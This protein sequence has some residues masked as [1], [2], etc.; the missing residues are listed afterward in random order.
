MAITPEWHL[1]TVTVGPTLG[2]GVRVVGRHVATLCLTQVMI[3]CYAGERAQLL[4]KG[5]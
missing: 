1:G 5:W 2:R 3:S 4:L